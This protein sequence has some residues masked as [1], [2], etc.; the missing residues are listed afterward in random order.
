MRGLA[1]VI[2]IQCHVFNSL[3]RMDVRDGGP[4]VLSQFIGGMAAPLFLFLVG[5]TLASQ[6]GSRERRE[7]VA[8]RRWLVSL[9]PAG[10]ILGVAFL[11]RFTNWAA[12]FPNAQTSEL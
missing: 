2:M 3:T 7:A 9:R 1:V 8:A 5:M 4:F 10:Y 11:F 12:S 6:M